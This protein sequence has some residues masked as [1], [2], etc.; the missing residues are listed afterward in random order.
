MKEITLNGGE[1]VTINPNV[2]MLTMFQFEK[3]TGYSLKNVIKSMMGSQGKE[4][5]L[6]EIDMFNALYLAYKTAN[7][8]GMTYDELAEKYIFDFV[9]LAEVFTSVIQ[10]EE[11]SNFLKGFKNKTTKKK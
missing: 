10:K 7:P 2:N 4:L 9:E 8:D 6:D 11:K 5:E 3:E 1:I